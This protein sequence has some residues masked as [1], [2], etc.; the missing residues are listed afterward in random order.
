MGQIKLEG[1][2]CEEIPIPTHTTVPGLF[3]YI[4]V[5]TAVRDFFRWFLTGHRSD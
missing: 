4:R 5:A 2:I 1:E 3:V